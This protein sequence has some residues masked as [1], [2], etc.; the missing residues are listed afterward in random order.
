MALPATLI[1]EFRTTASNNNG[2][3]FV[4]GGSGT[5]YSQQDA[6]EYNFA[7]LAI[8]AVDNTKVTSASHSFVAADVDNLINIT[9]GVNFTLERF[10][11]VSVAGGAATLDRACG[12]VG[13]VNGTYYL[14][15]ALALPTD[16]ILEAFI[17]GNIAYIEAGTYT[18]TGAI[19][20]SLDG[21]VTNPITI[22]GYNATRG[23]DPTGDDQPLIAA[24][25][26]SYS[27]DDD[28]I[29]ENI[30]CTS[31][32]SQGWRQDQ[33]GRW[34]NCKCHNSSGTADRFAFYAGGTG[35]VSDCES[36][37]DNGYG[38][39]AVNATRV[40]SS[41]IHDCANG[42][43]TS[44]NSVVIV[45]CI[46]DTCG[47][48]GILLGSNDVMSIISNT[49]YNCGIGIDATDSNRD[50]VMNNI[51]DSC[52]TGA[53]WTTEQGT[54]FFDYN[55]WKS[56]G[57]DVTNV[58]KGDNALAVDPQFTNAPNG[59]FSIGVNLKGAGFPGAFPGALSTGYLDV[60]A[61]QREESGGRRSRARRHGI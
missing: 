9:A 33:G 20:V 16:A 7:D 12:N 21:T 25:A 32:A 58:T 47:T 18:L 42:I 53:S 36:I 50:F 46:I 5:D 55:N 59:D 38:I 26:N 44:Q 10:R 19:D 57:T 49:I 40:R 3:A 60:G 37:C 22:I 43:V 6:A 24:A 8:D 13:S 30:R 14:G 11:I 2:G 35:L 61:V 27:F 28:W 54:N 52:T 31:T 4:D 51:I 56:N 41:N 17:P 23:D 15:G 29:Q 1:W 34:H 48:K 39:Y 45:N